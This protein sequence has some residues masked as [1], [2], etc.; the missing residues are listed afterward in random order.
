VIKSANNI[1]LNNLLAMIGGL[2]MEQCWRLEEIILTSEWAV[3][4]SW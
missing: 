4:C 2:F 1:W 3:V